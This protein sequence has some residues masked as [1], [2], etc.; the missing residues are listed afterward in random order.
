M[1]VV[2]DESEAELIVETNKLSAVD[3]TDSICV[4][5]LGNVAF[6][7]LYIYKDGA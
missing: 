2:E 5:V 7:G 4:N 1:E 3:T 6:G